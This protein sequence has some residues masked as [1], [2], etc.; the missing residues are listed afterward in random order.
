MPPRALAVHPDPAALAALENALRREGYEVTTAGDFEA[1]SRH[2]S[3]GTFDALVTAHRLGEY[4]GLHLLARAHLAMA[5]TA[6][7]VI[8]HA[9]EAH[10]ADEAAALGGIA[11]ETPADDP[12]SAMTALRAVVK[13]T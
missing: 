6:A 11:I 1:G 8:S 12:S 4:N 5:A 2:L 9:P 13:M 3:L 10:L 7:V